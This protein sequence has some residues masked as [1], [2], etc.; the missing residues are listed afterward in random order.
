LLPYRDT[1]AMQDHLAEISQAVDDDAHAP[2]S[3]IRRDGT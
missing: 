3:S 2:S 1:K